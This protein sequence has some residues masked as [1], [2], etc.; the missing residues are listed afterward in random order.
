MATECHLKGSDRDRIVQRWA[1]G[2]DALLSENG[3]E[4]G[5]ASGDVF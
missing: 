4:N 5:D 3:V 1:A 2:I